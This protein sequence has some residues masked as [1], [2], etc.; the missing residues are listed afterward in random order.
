MPISW[1]FLFYFVSFR[2]SDKRL[3]SSCFSV[4]IIVILMFFP[5][6]QIISSE[7]EYHAQ[8]LLWPVKTSSFVCMMLYQK[9]SIWFVILSRSFDIDRR[10]NNSA[11]GFVRVAYSKQNIVIARGYIFF[12]RNIVVITLSR[13]NYSNFSIS[14]CL[15]QR[16]YLPNYMFLKPTVV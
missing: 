2:R 11:H 14:G 9:K 16:A 1:V 6:F 15:H 10:H 7:S 12:H 8:P 13:V 4:R 5:C 3:G